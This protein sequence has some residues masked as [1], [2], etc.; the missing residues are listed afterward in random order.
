MQ[1]RGQRSR[2]TRLKYRLTRDLQREAGRLN[3]SQNKLA[4]LCHVSSGHMSQ[5]AN[6]LRHPGPD[7]RRRLLGVFKSLSFDQLFEEV[8]RND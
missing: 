8:T 6:G 4:E 3:I 5:I 2:G 7:V 1:E